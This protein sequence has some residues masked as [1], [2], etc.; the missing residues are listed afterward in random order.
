MRPT[1]TR[2]AL[3]AAL[4]LPLLLATGAPDALADVPPDAP[5]ASATAEPTAEPADAAPQA[6]EPTAAAAPRAAEPSAL[7]VAPSPDDALPLAAAEPLEPPLPVLGSVPP[8]PGS[9]APAPDPVD[10]Y[11]RY[12]PQATCDPTPKPGTVY[13]LDLALS[14]YGQGRSSGI[15]RGC[16]VG[17]TSEH[18]EGR[19]FDWAVN[20]ANPAQKA[21]GDAF[22][23]W[24]TA[25]GPDGKVGYNARRLGV[26]HVIW[27][28]YIWSNSSSGAGWRVYTADPPHTD[29]VHVSLSWA[30]A[31]QRTSWWT[32]VALPSD[33]EFRPYVRQVYADLFHRVPDPT[34]LETW[35]QALG[36]G[37]DRVAVANAITGSRE[38]RARLIAGVYAEML[39][40]SP[41]D[42]GLEAWLAQMQLGLT[43][44][45]LEAG[46]IASDEYYARNGGTPDGW[47]RGLYRDV[48]D[49]S[50]AEDEVGFW[51]G[52]LGAGASRQAVALGFVLSTERL[53]TVVEGYY[54]QLLDR[55]LDPVGR[56]GWVSAI[57]AGAR[58]EAII[59]GIVGSEEYFGRAQARSGS[60]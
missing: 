5:E 18:K 6:A 2:L 39:G 31:Y 54:Q 51:V 9:P 53:T 30:G 35:T 45:G 36:D 27:N 46:F 43:V 22:V 12:R 32:G 38:Y 14:T 48:L 23:Q 25:V 28:H 49:R 41:E 50:A 37:T 29:H 57:Q 15:S 13:L 10:G 42:A 26:M 55:G 1:T 11:A 47:V 16:S 24:L 20:V 40:R 4:V 44:P 52:R 58:T 17:G 7:A 34:G 21:A 8:G 33:A 59:G 60:R 3:S 19:A 56:A